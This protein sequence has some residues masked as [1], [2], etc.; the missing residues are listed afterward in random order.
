M[1]YAQSWSNRREKE[2]MWSNRDFIMAF[3]ERESGKQRIIP[4]R[5]TRA[6]DKIRTQ[7]Q[8]NINV[9][10]YRYTSPFIVTGYYPHMHKLRNLYL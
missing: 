8:P 10:H 3:S 6:T 5:V 9:E 7:H 2:K 1:P 4:V